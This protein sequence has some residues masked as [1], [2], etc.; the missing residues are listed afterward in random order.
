MKQE[1]ERGKRVPLSDSDIVDLYWKREEKAIDETDYKYRRYLYTVAY[2]VL[3]DNLDCEEC[4]NDTTRRGSL[5]GRIFER[6]LIFPLVDF[7]PYGGILF[8]HIVDTRTVRQARVG[9][10]RL[11]DVNRIFLHE[12]SVLSH[13]IRIL[14]CDE[15][16]QN[17]YPISRRKGIRTGL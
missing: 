9:C 13:H 14:H 3:Y 10:N 4:L 8:H 6:N 15:A 7:L 12:E 16:R 11:A 17:G 5:F 2:N 1:P